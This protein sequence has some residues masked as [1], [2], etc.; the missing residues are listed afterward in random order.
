VGNYRAL[1]FTD[2]ASLRQIRDRLVQYERATTPSANYARHLATYHLPSAAG[3]SDTD[4]G[5]FAKNVAREVDELYTRKAPCLYSAVSASERAVYFSRIPYNDSAIL[6]PDRER[7]R[8]VLGATQTFSHFG[9][10]EGFLIHNSLM[11]VDTRYMTAF[12]PL[13]ALYL[14]PNELFRRVGAFNTPSPWT[15]GVESL[16]DPRRRRIFEIAGIGTYLL[17]K[18]DFEKVPRSSD[19]KVIPFEVAARLAPPFVVVHDERSYGTAYLASEIYHRPVSGRDAW[20]LKPPFRSDADFSHY[21]EL[22]K[23]RRDEL[24][25][26]SKKHSAL[27]E[28]DSDAGI[29]R[30]SGENRMQILN[31]S[32]SKA[33]FRVECKKAPCWLV[34]NQ[35]ALS[36]W[37]AFAGNSP[38]A[39]HRVNFAFQGVK[40]PTGNAIVWFEYWPA[41]R[42]I[43]TWLSLLTFLV[44]LW[45]LWFS[46]AG[47]PLRTLLP[48]YR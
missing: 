36:G 27:I 47:L 21:A 22:V 40:V 18:E 26:L 30:A 42:V 2:H 7:F 41:S 10:G 37:Q 15:P 33:A 12:P 14:V 16:L 17:K 24:L 44:A 43:G 4:V 35:A 31:L 5:S 29:E 34:W 38:L 32:G 45:W 28:D 25:R 9:V 46:T 13:N 6:D 3:L 19:L 20:K 1:G 11:T 8:R 48:R 23:G 39:I